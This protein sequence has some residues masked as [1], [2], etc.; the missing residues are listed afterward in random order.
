MALPD[1][2]GR[3]HMTVGQLLAAGCAV[4]DR[5]SP[6]PPPQAKAEDVVRERLEGSDGS[7]AR[8]F[9]SATKVSTASLTRAVYPV[10]R[11]KD[12]PEGVFDSWRALRG[13][14]DV[15]EHD[16][17]EKLWYLAG[18][19]RCSVLNNKIVGGGLGPI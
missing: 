17:G 9:F 4:L 3:Y 15:G 19:C 16:S 18:V 12:T 11:H 13:G 8:S 14:G 5:L 1:V 7:A 6:V 2:Y 10:R